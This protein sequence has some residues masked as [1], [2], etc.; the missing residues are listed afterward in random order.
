M[1]LPFPPTPTRSIATPY[2]PTR[3]EAFSLPPSHQSTDINIKCVYL[4][5]TGSR[6]Y[7]I[8]VELVTIYIII[9]RV[10]AIEGPLY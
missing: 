9:S 5:R 1:P 8:Y 7:P 6:L 4:I 3:P 10:C 2:I